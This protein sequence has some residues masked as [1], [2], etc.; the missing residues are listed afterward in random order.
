MVPGNQSWWN[1]AVLGN[2]CLKSSLAQES[3]VG[4]LYRLSSAVA[5][6]KNQAFR[7]LVYRL[8]HTTVSIPS[9]LN[10]EMQLKTTHTT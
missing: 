8:T 9:R 2:Y 7:D 6:A 3:K 5:W 1:I 10:T 4:T